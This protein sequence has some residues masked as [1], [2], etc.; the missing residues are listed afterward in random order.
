MT[1]FKNIVLICGHYEGIDQRVIDLIVDDEIS[2]GDYI[3]TGGEIPSM[4]LIDAF[5]RHLDG[6]INKKSLIEESFLNNLLEYRQ[7]TRP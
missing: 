2:I 6:V 4:V 5:I 1:N 7:Y 3:L